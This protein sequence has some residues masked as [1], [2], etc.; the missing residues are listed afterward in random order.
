M[1]SGG[2]SILLGIMHPCRPV[3]KASP[4]SSSCA[5]LCRMAVPKL[6]QLCMARNILP[7]L[8]GLNSVKTKHTEDLYWAEACASST[9]VFSLPHRR[10]SSPGNPIERT[11]AADLSQNSS[12]SH[13]S[14][15]SGAQELRPHARF[16]CSG[17][18]W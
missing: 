1:A 9:Y 11:A 2:N 6:L 17:S 15:I 10:G 3:N 14:S 16:P 5:C 7:D 8:K 13:V 18:D 4:C 12:S